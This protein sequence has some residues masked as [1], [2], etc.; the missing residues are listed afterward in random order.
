MNLTQAIVS[1]L[2]TKSEPFGWS[3]IS[4]FLLIFVVIALL[5]SIEFLIGFA[6][7][8]MIKSAWRSISSEFDRANSKNRN[9][10]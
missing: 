7:R 2:G 1:K 10:G 5:G 4:T 9:D 3:D 8:Q 6:V